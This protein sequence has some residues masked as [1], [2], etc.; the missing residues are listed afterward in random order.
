M[1]LCRMDLDNDYLVIPDRVA[2]LQEFLDLKLIDECRI[3]KARYGLNTV[4]TRVGFWSQN[5]RLIDNIVGSDI[6]LIT[7]ITG[8]AGDRTYSNNFNI[9]KLEHLDRPYIDDFYATD[10]LS[11]LHADKTTV[12]NRC[13]KDYILQHSPEVSSSKI[14]VNQKVISK[15]Y[16]D[17]VGLDFNLD[18]KI[19]K[20]DIFFPFRLTDR[21]YKFEEVIDT[22]TDCNIFITDPNESFSKFRN[23][24]SNIKLIKPNKRE[25]YGILFNQPKI[26]Y[27]ENPQ[28]VFH[29]GLADFIY[30]N[31]DIICPYEIP[32]L[33]EVLN[34]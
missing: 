6:P 17:L 10:V 3:I 28:E 23:P 5:T 29:P 4:D 22:Y 7:D 1:H 8:Y 32:K 33:K 12:L 11:I 30:F 21:A 14:E 13:Q 26:V 19:G 27:N 15:K 34:D 25:Y 18:F 16:F 20:N 31:C 24:P 2:D 9:T